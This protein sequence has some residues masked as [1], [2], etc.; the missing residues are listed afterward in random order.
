MTFKHIIL[1]SLA[2]LCALGASAVPA[3]P[4]LM[5]MTQADGSE[6]QVRLIG[7]EFSHYYL[8]EDGYLLTTAGRNF[9]YA[10]L[11]A[12][13][14][15]VSS[16][17][18]ATPA[19]TRP[20]AATRFLKG[21]DKELM[22]G[23]MAR[24]REAAIASGMT[25]A[26]VKRSQASVQ[27]EGE[28]PARLPGLLPGSDFPSMGEQKALVLLVNYTDVKMTT[29]DAHM[30]FS[31]LLNEPG[32]S[33]NGATG[34]ARDYF[35]ECSEG[36]FLP[37]FDVYGPVE[38]PYPRSYYGGN[39]R[40]GNDEYAWQMVTDACRIL[41]D[42]VDF[43]Q[44]DRD[45]DGYIDNVFVF[46]AGKGEATGGGDDT[47]WPHSWE[48]EDGGRGTFEFDGVIANRYAC[49]NELVGF[50]ADGVGT[51]IHEFSHVMGLP[52]LYAT[53]G[54]SAFT[55]DAWS[56]LDYG[57]YNNNGHTPPLYGAFERAALGWMTPREISGPLSVEL[58]PISANVAGVIRTSS[59]NEYFLLE[60][61][62]QT[63]WDTYIPGHGMLVWHI[64]Y[65]PS[66]WGANAV[67]NTINHQYVDIVEADGTKSRYT[68]GG[69]SFPGTQGVTEFT[70]DTHPSMATWSGEV[71][72][73]PITE[74]TETPEGL[75][76]FKVC[77][78]A[79]DQEF[80]TTSFIEATDVMHTSFRVAWEP[81]DGARYAVS[82]YEA[83][84]ETPLRGYDHII[85]GTATD[86][87][88]TGLQPDTE[89]TCRVYIGNDWQFGES[90]EP[91]T[92][93]TRILSLELL[94]VK[95]LPA[96]DVTST[97]FTASWEVLDRATEHLL[98]VYTLYTPEVLTAGCDFDDRTIPEGWTINFDPTFSP[99]ENYSGDGFPAL[100]FTKNGHML[101]SPVFT[102]PVA[103]LSF[104]HL[105]TKVDV[106]NCIRLFALVD[107]EWVKVKDFDLS[108]K[109]G[110]E[111]VN[112][113][114]FP[115]GT[116]ALR[117]DFVRGTS[118]G[119]LYIDDIHVECHEPYERVY[120]EGYEKRPVGTASTHTVE[121]L[122]PGTTYY[123]TV[124][125]TDGELNAITSDPV[126][127]TLPE[128]SGLSGVEVA[129]GVAIRTSEGVVEVYGLGSGERVI[130]TDLLGRTVASALSS[131]DVVS[132]P[133]SSGLYI[134][135]AGATVR[136][137]LVR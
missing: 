102:L 122:T 131:G 107:D 81:V 84:S 132:L 92:V 125:A 136:K 22:I 98:T 106:E 91:L 137:I 39:D 71:L 73:L 45:H 49:S 57:P 100:G 59:E 34:S 110:G 19:A 50:S 90:S 67:N 9:Y 36:K 99:N 16:G 119:Q 15:P 54:S 94:K 93:R 69:D 30:Y 120:L 74:I 77:G 20:E 5:T 128:E 3:K 32:F 76:T 78:G 79:V 88:F 10:D 87:E 43:S 61:R 55:P 66:I 33:Q 89:Y 40:Y 35:E 26:S 68:R 121:N 14:V 53:N 2:S 80:P 62:Q 75:I 31:G 134:V 118:Y 52:D 47:V 38:L 117:F 44:Y 111:R 18:K 42:E 24:R 25:K 8:S 97:S 11:D 46:Y 124:D 135:K 123:Y 12:A 83:G 48:L 70:D 108:K 56:V 115:A 6:I 85:T 37:E 29:P 133:V 63:G 4:G 28:L 86:Y 13:G 23:A 105:A 27:S 116:M 82:L 60:N 112:F 7:D 126:S 101:T 21:V 51:F 109:S 41:D 64:H 127:V 72:A 65:V 96:E 95:A 103:S 17:I 130:V 113:D 129:D 114:R 104:W 1:S 58:E